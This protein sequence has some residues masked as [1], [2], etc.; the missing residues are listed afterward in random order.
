MSFRNSKRRTARRNTSKTRQRLS[1]ASLSYGRCE[2]RLALATIVV[3]TP[4]DVVDAGDGL[5]SLRE[6]VTA[7]NTNAVF[8]DAA[9]GDETGDR[10]IFSNLFSDP[11]AE[12][13]LTQGE[14]EITD[15]VVIRGFD[16]GDF[17]APLISGAGQSR[18]FNVDTTETVRLHEVSL[19]DGNAN[20]FTNQGNGGLINVQPDSDL[21]IFKS[22]LSSGFAD[23]GGALYV[24]SSRVVAIGGSRFSSNDVATNLTGGGALSE[25]G[26]I[27][28][29]DSDIK[30]AGVEFLGNTAVRGGAIATSGGSLRLFSSTFGGRGIGDGNSAEYGG[31]V[32]SEDTSILTNSTFIGNRSTKSGGAISSI[33]NIL[34]VLPGSQFTANGPAELPSTSDLTHFGGAIDSRNDALYI[35]DATFEENLSSS[36]GAISIRADHAVIN[37]VSVSNNQARYQGGGI[38]VSFEND[39][40]YIT[41][42]TFDGNHAVGDPDEGT[43]G[44]GGALS[45]LA[46]NGNVTV[47]RR[48]VMNFNSSSGDGGAIYATSP[49]E[50]GQSNLYVYGSRLNDNVTNGGA[51]G[52]IYYSNGT[53]TVA[54]SQFR[55]NASLDELGSISTSGS[56]GAIHS[57]LARTLIYNSGFVSNMATENG[58]ALTASG[59]YMRVASSQLNFNG[60]K[61][62]GAA[63]A[64][65]ELNFE[66][67]NMVFVGGTLDGNSAETGGAIAVTPESRL[68]ARLGVNFKTNSAND[69]GAIHSNGLVN[70]N[71]VTFDGNTAD[72]GGAVLLAEESLG[73]VT[74]STFK[75]NQTGTGNGSAIL[76]R[77]SAV[78]SLI[79]STFEENTS[80]DNPNGFPVFGSPFN[81]LSESGLTFEAN[82]PNNGIGSD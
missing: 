32:H 58:G 52:A 71:G 48:V 34:H 60:S 39:G 73:F 20:S 33:G 25:G 21:V 30:I 18:I 28:A 54:G 46:G 64:G 41:D 19:T 37:R 70:L 14:L 11:A 4:L 78:L 29:V 26:A 12:I 68:V 43:F 42:S 79:D 59:G 53:L 40:A 67:S 61:T 5:I 3:T 27:Y 17:E 69:G 55:R 13:V 56:G 50:P 2:P 75:G 45:V 8:S 35:A 44:V 74:S 63:F 6:A 38:S 51:G 62:G 16:N 15:D 72:S 66:P 10:I 47:L 7:A 65:G 36:G 76:S 1:N 9:A 22:H 57:L 80:T 77:G 24:D 49:P 82:T 81:F 31:A 23:Q